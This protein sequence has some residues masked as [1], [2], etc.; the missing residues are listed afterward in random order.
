MQ[1]DRT[2]YFRDFLGFSKKKTD[3]TSFVPRR[4]E[5]SKMAENISKL[6][7]KNNFR[8]KSSLPTLSESSRLRLLL[9]TIWQVKINLFSFVFNPIH[10]QTTFNAA[11]FP[12]SSIE[13][14]SY[15]AGDFAMIFNSPDDTKLNY[16]NNLSSHRYTGAFS[17][18]FIYA[19]KNYQ[20]ECHVAAFG[21][22]MWV[23][24]VR[25]QSLQLFSSDEIILWF[26]SERRV[27][28]LSM[29]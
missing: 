11:F 7:K 19:V 29:N 4:L 5:K 12:S 16:I 26:T 3:W 22:G 24:F 13:A 18:Y 17:Y 15:E 8:E 27:N 2:F 25:T 6:E 1:G 20:G 23:T 21:G 10:H 9:R 14:F 28:R